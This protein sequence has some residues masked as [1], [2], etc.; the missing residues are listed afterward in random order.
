MPRRVVELSM[1]QSSFEIRP[2][3][4]TESSDAKESDCIERCRVEL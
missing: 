1:M 2:Q 4:Y 3:K